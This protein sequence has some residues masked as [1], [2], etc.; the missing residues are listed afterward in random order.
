MTDYT[1]ARESMVDSQIHP[2][3]VISD[4]VLNAFLTTPR[5]LYV[6]RKSPCLRLYG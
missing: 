5:E 1:K 3:G 4:N 6:P 2:L